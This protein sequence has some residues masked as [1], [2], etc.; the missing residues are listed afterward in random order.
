M[1]YFIVIYQHLKNKLHM[2]LQKINKQLIYLDTLPI[3]KKEIVK[4]KFAQIRK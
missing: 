1:Y 2:N 3:E 4:R